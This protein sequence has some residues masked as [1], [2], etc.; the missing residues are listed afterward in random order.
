M[1]SNLKY[2]RMRNRPY[3]CTD[4]FTV[5]LVS[6]GIILVLAVMLTPLLQNSKAPPV[7][8]YSSASSIPVSSIS[9][10]SIFPS[11]SSSV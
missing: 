3:D 9:V 10:S 1:R 11:S 2:E 5:P 8:N 6:F 7:T 4:F